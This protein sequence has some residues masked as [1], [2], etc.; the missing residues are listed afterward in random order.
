MLYGG[1]EYKRI[2]VIGCSGS[3]KSTFSKALSA[4]TGIP[5]VHLDAHWWLPGWQNTAKDEFDKWQRA[6]VLEESWIFDGNFSRTLEIRFERADMVIDFQIPRRQCLFGVISR[7]IRYRGKTRSDM[8]QGCR[9]QIDLEFLRFV[10]TFNKKEL[11]KNQELI[12]KYP[13]MK[14]VIFKSR[15]DADAFLRRIEAENG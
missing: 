4:R 11:P 1:K 2:A 8:G 13:K 7:R 5:A 9:E 15:K 12:G 10:W 6:A 14:H 3:G